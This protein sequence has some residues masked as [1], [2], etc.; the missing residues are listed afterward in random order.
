MLLNSST[1][2]EIALI[3]SDSISITGSVSSSGFASSAA[4]S[5]FSGSSTTT[6]FFFL[7]GFSPSRASKASS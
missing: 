3:L 5:P 1:I 4:L 7:R 2:V 6:S